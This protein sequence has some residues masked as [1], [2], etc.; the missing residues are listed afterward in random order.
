MNFVPQEWYCKSGGSE[1]IRK[2]VKFSDIFT[3]INSIW[4]N[5]VIT[6]ILPITSWTF[7]GRVTWVFER[8]TGVVVNF[9]LGF[10]AKWGAPLM[11]L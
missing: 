8:P 2:L 3:A 9:G 11:C 5:E 10:F 4:D 6:W 7:Q 1:V